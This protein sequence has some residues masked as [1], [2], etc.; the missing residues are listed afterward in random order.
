MT[1]DELKQH[2]QAVL[3][4]ETLRELAKDYG[5]VQRA[6]ELDI[7]QLVI[8]LVLC[9]GTHEGGRQFDVLRRYVAS[10]APKVVRGAF[11]GWFTAPLEALLTEL[12]CR[13]ITVGRAQIGRAH[14]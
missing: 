2:M 3:P 1:G 5:V 13:A 11:Y 10:G 12:L 7:V 14:V 6:R 9:G 8:A 4:L